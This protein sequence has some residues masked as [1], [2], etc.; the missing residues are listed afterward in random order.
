MTVVGKKKYPPVL[1]PCCGSRMMWFDKENSL[2]V[3][4]DKRT[5]NGTAMDR[6][7]E[8]SIIVD[9]DTVADFKS[10]PFPND[11][12]YHIAFDPPHL[13]VAGDKSWMYQKYGKLP[14]DWRAELL[15]GFTECIRVLKPYD[16]LI[17]K[18]SEVQIPVREVLDIVIQDPQH[19]LLYG[20][21]SG[22]AANTHWMSF[23]KIPIKEEQKQYD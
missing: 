3:F 12:F 7:N 17:F 18:W 9:P 4:C 19:K 20:H 15:E 2:V 21:K 8:R 14:E 1:D 16:T 6:G 22:K 5:H 10:L 23:M 11:T 13:K